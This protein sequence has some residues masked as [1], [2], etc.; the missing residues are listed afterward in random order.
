MT[1][2][3]CHYRPLLQKSQ[4]QKDSSVRDPVRAAAR[5]GLILMRPASFTDD[6]RAGEEVDGEVRQIA[7][8]EEHAERDEGEFTPIVSLDTLC[9]TID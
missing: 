4:A 1:L 9:D 7:H 2:T 8:E 5:P 3:S 6:G